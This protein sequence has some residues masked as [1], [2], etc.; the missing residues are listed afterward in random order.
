MMCIANELGVTTPCL[1]S[2]GRH[3]CK[4]RYCRCSRGANKNPYEKIHDAADVLGPRPLGDKEI[5]VRALRYQSVS[6]S[7][8]SAMTDVPAAY[9][10]MIYVPTFTKMGEDETKPD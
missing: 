10:R 8:I 3:H 5:I 6:T 2:E 9:A 4:R 1:L 7:V